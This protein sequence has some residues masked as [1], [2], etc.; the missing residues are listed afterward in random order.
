[1]INEGQG[2]ITREQIGSKSDE[3]KTHGRG[4][5]DLAW[6]RRWLIPRGS[7]RHRALGVWKNHG[8]RELVRRGFRRFVI[9]PIIHI[10]SAGNQ[11]T[12]A[13][14]DMVSYLRGEFD[15]VFSVSQKAD[16]QIKLI[17]QYH[18]YYLE[19]FRFTPHVQ[20]TCNIC[21]NPTVFFCKNARFPRD[22]LICTKCGS[23]SRYRSIARGILRAI[24]ELVGIEARSLAQLAALKS[25]KPLFIHDT[26]TPFY[27]SGISYPIPDLLAR[28]NWI[29]LSLSEYLTGKAPGQKLGPITTVQNLEALTFEDNSLDILITSDVMEHVRLED[30]AH[31][32]IRR[33]LRPGRVYLFT[34]PHHR[35]PTTDQY[36]EIVDPLDPKKDRFLREPVYH[37]DPNSEDSSILVYRVYGADLDDRLRALGFT[38]DYAKQDCLEQ[39]IMDTEL[40]YCRLDHK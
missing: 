36:V 7:L 20:G 28:C 35:C 10:A 37:G 29:H 26:Q 27:F 31:Q 17:Q 30:R 15:G 2:G 4:A 38:V 40:F 19:H 13:H 21:G 18:P 16:D 25:T 11:P 12:P 5:I 22:F 39:G 33:V 32:E 3:I 24:K 6:T 1:L 8:L 23:S 34:V 14:F 9:R